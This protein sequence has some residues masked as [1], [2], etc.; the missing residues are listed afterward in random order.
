MISKVLTAFQLSN[1]HV[2]KPKE[3]FPLMYQNE[4]RLSAVV[5]PFDFLIRYRSGCSKRMI[6]SYI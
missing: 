3:L 5:W 1:V 4:S 2:P 6:D